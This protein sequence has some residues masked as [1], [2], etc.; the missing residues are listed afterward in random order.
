MALDTLL[1]SK[2][3]VGVE[4]P[5]LVFVS[6]LNKFLTLMHLSN[7]TPSNF[8]D[9]FGWIL[10]PFRK[11]SGSSPGG[12]VWDASRMSGAGMV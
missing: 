12:V 7:V 3:S 4:G 9:V 8:A 5:T 11:S 2:M 6:T 10:W 1:K